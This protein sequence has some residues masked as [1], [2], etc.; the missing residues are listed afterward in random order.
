MTQHILSAHKLLLEKLPESRTINASMRAF[1][2]LFV[3]CASLF[4]LIKCHAAASAFLATTAK[5][6]K[7]VNQ[8]K[9]ALFRL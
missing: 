3:I 2:L 5:T 9:W 4:I 6:R 7:R 8:E 1:S